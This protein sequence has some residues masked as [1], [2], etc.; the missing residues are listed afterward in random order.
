MPNRVSPFHHSR[1]RFTAVAAVAC[2][3]I[4]LFVLLARTGER[5]GG[6]GLDE[7]MT[8]VF[9]ELPDEHV[10]PAPDPRPTQADT[11][12]AS[13]RSL[14]PL[15][16][17]DSTAISQPDIDWHNA[18]SRAA[19]RTAAAP[20]MNDFGFPTR[21]PA[22]SEK[23]VFGWDKT[24]TERV[25]AL[26]GGGMLIRLSDNCAI[27]LAPLPLGGCALGKRKA[28]GDLFDEMQAPAELGDW[29]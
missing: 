6:V 20:E 16:A 18:A 24:H 2:G 3:H 5:D 7:R 21:E 13:R 22:P 9:F 14:I 29:K 26:P 25:S 10:E 28:R 4:A 15:A 27:T 1:A 19:A 11:S 23:K 12:S 17:P 8:L